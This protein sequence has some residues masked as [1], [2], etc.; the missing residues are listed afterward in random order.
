MNYLRDSW[1]RWLAWLLLAIVFAVACGFLS[2]WQFNRRTEALAKMNQLASNYDRQPVDL[3]F[4]KFKSKDEWLPIKLTG[5]F[6][7]ENTLLVRNRPYNGDPGFLELIPF[8]RQDGLVLAIETGWLP[9]DDRLSPPKNF[10]KPSNET[11]TIWGRIRPSEP[12]LNRDAPA[13]QIGT[14]NVPS[15]MNKIGVKDRAVDE[16]Y[17]SLGQNN[18]ASAGLPKLLARPQLDE[19]NHLSYALQWIVFAL[20]AFA[21][22]LWAIRQEIHFKRLA[23]DPSYKP[24]VRKKVGDD[25]NNAEDLLLLS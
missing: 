14:I 12:T 11:Q 3:G 2:N 15:F 16:F 22:L 8:Q 20:L 24:K 23:T 7:P 5:H 9:A 13:G 25:D 17:L 6:L 10:P 1:R 18:F 21:A 4:T 19:G